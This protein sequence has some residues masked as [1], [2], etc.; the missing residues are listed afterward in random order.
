MRAD[1]CVP[2]LREQ[3]V[4]RR[5]AQGQLDIIEA[6]LRE[7]LRPARLHPAVGFAVTKFHYLVV[8][9]A[10][11]EL[12]LPS[13]LVGSEANVAVRACAREMG[14]DVVDRAIGLSV[15]VRKVERAPPEPVE[16]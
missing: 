12:R 1:N 4:E 15:H 2:D 5:D 16:L 8:G 13:R 7:T 9:N 14:V 6:C 10:D 11:A 3:L